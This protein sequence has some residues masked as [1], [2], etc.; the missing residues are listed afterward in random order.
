MTAHKLPGFVCVGGAKCGTT[1]LY[2]YLRG[3]PGIF[4]PAQKELHFF[5]APDLLQRPNGPRMRSVLD[6]IVTTEA[7]YR[8]HFAGMREGQIGGDISPSYLNS[9]HAPE[10]ICELLGA[11]KIIILLR[12]PVDRMFSQYMHLRRAAREELSFEDALAAENER[13][14]Q[15]WGDMW[16]YRHSAY[17]AERVRRY[18]ET[19]GRDNVLVV[20]SEQ[21]RGDLPATVRTILEFIGVSPDVPLDLTGEFN[22]S[23]LPKSKAL[24]KLLDASPFATLA[25]RLVPRRLGSTVKR[26]LQEMNTGDRI[27]LTSERKAQ[28]LGEFA[29]DI[30]ELERV[31]GR[32]TGWID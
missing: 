24:A 30:R 15:G 11:P 14:A 9:E 6:D 18:I 29:D 4:L 13:S 23:G 20:I 31:I 2:E 8:R 16:L 7:E 17:A 10:A 26:R 28:Y 22:K 12:N 21:M 19:F 5:S 25:K 32:S 1:S 3:H 27:V